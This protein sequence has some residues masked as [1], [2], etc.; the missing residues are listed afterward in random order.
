MADEQGNGVYL[1][2]WLGQD[3]YTSPKLTLGAP[4]V[5][6]IMVHLNDLTEVDE[7]DPEGMSPLN[8]M[9]DSINTIDAA[10]MLKMP[11]Q[12]QPQPQRMTSPDGGFTPG[13]PDNQ[14]PA[15]DAPSCN[16]GP[17]KFKSGV[18]KAGK[19][20]KGYFCTAPY[21]QQQCK[22]QFL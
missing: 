14:A 2:L 11:Q 9:L 6:G 7:T 21:G 18:S 17:M 16:H 12:T 5:A 4:N 10:V 8:S 13:M 19:P 20:Y 22:A 15:N 1:G 3:R